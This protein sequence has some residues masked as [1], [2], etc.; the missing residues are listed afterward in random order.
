MKLR[1]L[2]SLTSPSRM[3]PH[4]I[5]GEA[6]P[7]A[8]AIRVCREYVMQQFEEAQENEIYVCGMQ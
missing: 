6:E 2:Y 4:A 5:Q 1:C 3:K 8:H 7:T